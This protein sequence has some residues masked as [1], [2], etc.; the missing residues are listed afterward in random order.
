MFFFSR[1]LALLALLY[2]L[3]TYN[4]YTIYIIRLS[5]IR[6][7]SFTHRHIQ[8]F[9]QSVYKFRRTLLLWHKTRNG[10]ARKYLLSIGCKLLPHFN[11][12]LSQSR[13]LAHV[14]SHTRQ[15][16]FSH[17]FSRLEELLFIIF[18]FFF[19]RSLSSLHL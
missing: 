9:V 13:S 3:Y 5:C 1:L 11:C 18:Y 15:T 6:S 4:I 16:R 2:I 17:R 7:N 12:H 8:T 14:V 19:H 10:R